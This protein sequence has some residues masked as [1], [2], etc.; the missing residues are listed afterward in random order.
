[1]QP[2]RERFPV[3]VRIGWGSI[4]WGIARGSD[5]S[6]RFGYNSAEPSRRRTHPMNKRK[7]VA[8][9]KHRAKA[10][11]QEEKRKLGQL[12]RRTR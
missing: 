6:G 8:I 7:R 5:R 1:V 9:Q 11:K 2:S 12:A 10:K 4:D 3:G